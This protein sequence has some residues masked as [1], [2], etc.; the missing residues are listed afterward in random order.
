MPRKRGIKKRFI[1]KRKAVYGKPPTRALAN[2]NVYQFKRTISTDVALNPGD[3]FWSSE[4]NN[5]G[6]A[7]ALSI[8]TGKHLD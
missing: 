7:F 3:S 1:R 6:K 8:V 2:P 5:I 4:G